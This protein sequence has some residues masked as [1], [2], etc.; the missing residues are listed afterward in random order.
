MGPEPVIAYP[1]GFFDGVATSSIGGVFI[2]LSISHVHSF[3][4]KLGCGHSTNTK[5]ELLA[6]W[7]LLYFAEAIGIPSLHI[8]GDSSIIIDWASR[9]VLYVLVFSIGES[10][11]PEDFF[12]FN[13]FSGKLIH[14]L[15]PYRRN[16]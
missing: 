6:L 5:D 11:L 8:F 13:T 14:P 7:V 15:I 12:N 1:F 9:N 16:P 3:N 4:L 10:N 2:Y